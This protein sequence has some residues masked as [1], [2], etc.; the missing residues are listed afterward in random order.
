MAKF[1]PG[2][3]DGKLVVILKSDWVSSTI[4]EVSGNASEFEVIVISVSLLEKY[5]VPS[6]W[7]KYPVPSTLNSASPSNFSSVPPGPL[8]SSPSTR[9]LSDT[10]TWLVRSLNLS[11]CSSFLQAKHIIITIRVRIIAFRLLIIITFRFN[12]RLMV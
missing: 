9:R 4:L 11:D 1:T 7:P 6:Y 12:N 3:P 10:Q 8:A 2:I 5:Q